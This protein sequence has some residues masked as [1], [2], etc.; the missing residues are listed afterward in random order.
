[1]E[2]VEGLREVQALRRLNPHE[3]IID[4]TEVV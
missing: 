2:E 4:L 1:M 3:H